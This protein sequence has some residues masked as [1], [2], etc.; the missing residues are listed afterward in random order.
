MQLCE[1]A[2]EEKVEVVLGLRKTILTDDPAGA[3]PPP[4]AFHLGG[5]CLG[6]ISPRI[7]STHI[8]SMCACG[9]WGAEVISYFRLLDFYSKTPCLFLP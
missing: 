2:S 7:L 5:C 4:F 9:T 3:W 6:A 8:L 1:Y